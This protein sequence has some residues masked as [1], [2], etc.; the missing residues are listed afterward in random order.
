[1]DAF[2]FLNRSLRI[3]GFDAWLRL[4]VPTLIF[5]KRLQ[6]LKVNVSGVCAFCG[7]KII[8]GEFD[9]VLSPIEQGESYVG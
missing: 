6:A 8:S 3:A 9:R 2:F 1:L 4:Q 5:K 7:G